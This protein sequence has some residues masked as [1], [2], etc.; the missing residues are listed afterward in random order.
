M[1][2]GTAKEIE[3]S[4]SNAINYMQKKSSRFNIL[5]VDIL[6]VWGVLVF[7]NMHKKAI[8]LNSLELAEILLEYSDHVLFGVFFLWYRELERMP[9]V[10]GV[11]RTCVSLRLMHEMH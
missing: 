8:R 4:R 7:D 9:C 2:S 5:L 11:W 1:G 6:A 10:C 3:C